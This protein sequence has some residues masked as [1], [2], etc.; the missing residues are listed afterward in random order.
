MTN[1]NTGP[2]GRPRLP[3]L[4]LSTRGRALFLALLAL[5]TTVPALALVLAAGAPA[6][7]HGTPMKPGSRTFLCWQ[8]ALT[9]TGEIKPVNPAC[10]AAQQ[11]SGTTPFYNWFSVLRSDGAGRTRGFVPDGELC[12]GGNPN[13]TG[14]D[15]PRDD[16]PVTH[17]TSGAT[18]DFSYN[19]W[20]A[21]PGW[22]YVYVTK[23]GYDPTRPLTWDEMEDT[24]FLTV[25]HP[26]L[27]GTPGTVE[28]NYSWTGQL[29][30][31]K[32]G[33]HIIYMVWHRSDS[34]ETFYSCSDVVFDGGNGEVTGIHDPGNPTQPPPGT[35]TAT[36]TTTN[37][38]PG[39]YQSEVTVT[40]SGDVAM[41]GWMVDWTLPGGQSVASLWNG[42]ATYRGQDV[43][44]H[45][46]DWNGSLSPGHSTTFGYVVQGDGGD[47]ATD[48]PCQVG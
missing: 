21:H 17:L 37:S 3:R 29:P 20:A 8:D 11:V 38:W 9:D 7:A 43:M 44:V 1:A 12:S 18:V 45:N 26:P 25:D 34:T 22:F 6:Q 28:A 47:S 35:C 27:N 36:R 19:A 41:L 13:F 10:K 30:A 23:D 31:N 40:N 2:S 24:P 15:L 39:G 42:N 32:T 33:R 5:L 46:A 48:L 14:F 16:W 4:P